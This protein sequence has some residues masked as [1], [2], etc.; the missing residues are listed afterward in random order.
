MAR[1]AKGMARSAR[2]K[3]DAW[4]RVR[5]GATASKPVGRECKRRRDGADMTIMHAESDIL[6]WR[7]AMEQMRNACRLLLR[8]HVIVSR[9]REARSEVNKTAF[10]NRKFL[11]AKC[12]II[13]DDCH[14]WKVKGEQPSTRAVDRWARGR[15]EDGLACARRV[16]VLKCWRTAPQCSLHA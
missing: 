3:R 6:T 13:I 12:G 14:S 4:R 10:S 8:R 5:V 7:H 2:C 16:R 15:E 9:V 11:L 1:W